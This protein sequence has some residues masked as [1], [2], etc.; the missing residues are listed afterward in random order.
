[1]SWV[2]SQA[3]WWWRLRQAMARVEIGEK[4]REIDKPS[5]PRVLL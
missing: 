3:R 2:V 1:M 4:E 5:C